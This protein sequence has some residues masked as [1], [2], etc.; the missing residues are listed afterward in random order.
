MISEYNITV[1][2]YVHNNSYDNYIFRDSPFKR[3]WIRSA[4]KAAEVQLYYVAI[5]I[6]VQ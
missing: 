1:T 3:D 6:I 5:K 2:L 4:I